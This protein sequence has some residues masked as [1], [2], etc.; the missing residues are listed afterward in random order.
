M[1]GTQIGPIPAPIAGQLRRRVD[2]KE[3]AQLLREQFVLETLFSIT[4]RFDRGVLRL[5]N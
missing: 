3:L 4:P 2:H 5:V 1:L